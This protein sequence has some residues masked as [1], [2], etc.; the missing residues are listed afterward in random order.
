MQS[1]HAL[2]HQF[3]FLIGTIKTEESSFIRRG[4]YLRFQF[5]IG[6]IKTFLGS[7]IFWYTVQRFNSL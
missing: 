7:A 4:S 5:L 2:N 6:T 1:S 3:Q